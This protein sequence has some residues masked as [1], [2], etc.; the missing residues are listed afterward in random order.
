MFEIFKPGLYIDFMGKMRWLLGVSGLLVAVSIALVATRGLNFGLDFS[1]GYEVQVLLP[2]PATEAEIKDAIGKVGVDNARVQRYGDQAGKEYL[3]LVREQGSVRDE[4]RAAVRDD[5]DK[6]AGDPQ[7]VEGWSMAESGETLHVGFT[8]PV[9]EQQVRSTLEKRGLKVK[10]I[11]RGEREDAPKYS[12]ELWSTG[13]LIERGLRD[14]LKVS[15]DV[16]IV[17]RVEF[18]GPQVGAQLRNQGLMALV[19]A[20]V[21]LLLYIA[22]RFDF[23]FSPGAIVAVAHDVI[24]TL[25]V[26][27]LF[28]IEF[29]MSTV[30]A[31]LTIIGYSINDTI[32]VYDRVRENLAK[33]KG[34]ELRHLVSASVSETLSRTILT[35]STIAVVVALIVFGGR[36]LADFSVA[37]LVG[38]IAGTYSSFSIAAPCYVLLRERFD[39]RTKSDKALVAAS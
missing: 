36:D 35:S 16:D 39:R 28:Q 3:I 34:R 6:L 20:L 38:F 19:Y 7:A 23:Y 30:A 21:F 9:S 24:I 11:T 8:V 22:V 27:A 15:P 25:G 37:M 12:I 5:F 31:L 13:A 4:E 17:R 29:T 1:G 26:F 32:V 2:Q 18:V 14:G 10:S 33:Y